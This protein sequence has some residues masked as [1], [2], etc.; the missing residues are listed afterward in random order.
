MRPGLVEPT[1]GEVGFEGAPLP[2]GDPAASLA[3]GVAT[4]YQELDLVDDLTVADNMFLGHELRRGP[5]ID[6]RRACGAAATDAAGPAGPRRDPTPG[7]G[8]RAAARPAKQVVSIARAL[9]R[10]AR[11]LIMDEPSAVLG[12]H[13]VETLFGVVRRLTA[14]GVGVVYISHRLEEVA[15]IGDIITVLR[16]GRTVAT[17]LARRHARAR[18]D[19]GHGRPASSADASS[20]SGTRHR[21]RTPVVAATSWA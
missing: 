7:A 5:I 17:A 21:R 19:H 8:R 9:T 11:L 18:A 20:R 3:R 12:R 1:A 15:A 6:R 16:D 10:R 14:E 2:P 4:I 13:E